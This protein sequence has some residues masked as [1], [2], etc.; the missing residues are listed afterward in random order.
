MI[1][2][3]GRIEI[4]RTIHARDWTEGYR[5][6]REEGIE[7]MRKQVKGVCSSEIMSGKPAILPENVDYV[8]DCLL[9]KWRLKGKR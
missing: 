2:S 3:M 5:K 4:D 7:E 9:G 1:D 6:G 8:A